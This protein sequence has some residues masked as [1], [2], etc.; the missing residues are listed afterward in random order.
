MPDGSAAGTGSETALTVHDA[1]EGQ[2]RGV[3]LGVAGLRNS[4]QG[5]FGGLYGAP[6]LLVLKEETNIW[7]TMGE[8]RHPVDVE[9]MGGTS[10]MLPYCD[11]DVKDGSVLYMRLANGGGY[12]DPLDRDPEAVLRDV[13]NG[14]VSHEV[15]RDIYGVA[16]GSSQTEVDAA[17]TE[18]LRAGIR[19]QR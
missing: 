6:S 16:L 14:L 12:G 1:P 10:E 15:A 3:A 8:N 17:A 4:G 18:E 11:F 7:D 9:A 19:A 2:I 5:L 13:A